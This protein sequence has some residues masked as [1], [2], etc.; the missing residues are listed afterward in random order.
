[1]TQLSIQVGLMILLSMD[2]LRI[3]FCWVVASVD[4][5][6]DIAE[7]FRLNIF[8]STPWIF[9]SLEAEGDGEGDVRD[10]WTLVVLSC[11]GCFTYA[12]WIFCSLEDA[13][14]GKDGICVTGLAL[15]LGILFEVLGRHAALCLPID[16]KAVGRLRL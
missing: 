12:P 2:S 9:R 3:S 11:F 4:D 15:F 7:P 10:Y 5:S 6:W 13:D 16:Q 1:M 14:D 8:A